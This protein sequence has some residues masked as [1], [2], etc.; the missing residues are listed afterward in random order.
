M[1]A[2]F[3]KKKQ[4]RNSEASPLTAPAAPEDKERPFGVLTLASLLD[5][6][7]PKYHDGQS[8]VDFGPIEAKLRADHVYHQPNLRKAKE[9]LRNET[10]RALMHPGTKANI[11]ALISSG[12]NMLT[13]FL[14]VYTD[15]LSEAK[16]VSAAMNWTGHDGLDQLT[17]E[18][19]LLS[20]DSRYKLVRAE[21]APVIAAFKQQ[22]SE[23]QASSG[24]YVDLATDLGQSNPPFG[25]P[26][27]IRSALSALD[28]ASC[29]CACYDQAP[30]IGAAGGPCARCAP[31]L[32]IGRLLW[33]LFCTFCVRSK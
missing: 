12:R 31:F 3:D 20:Q 28:D 13:D 9:H 33:H 32:T 26:L 17:E 24:N 30:C 18:H 11:Q 22:M 27:L 8:R 1:K 7:L 5:W 10:F 14:H 4:Q 25:A 29:D 21:H 23:V 19:F 2:Y 15:K 16:S 6:V